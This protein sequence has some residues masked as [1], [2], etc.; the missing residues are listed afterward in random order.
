MERVLKIFAFAAVVLITACDNDWEDHYNSRPETVNES[1]WDAIQREE[2]LSLFVQYMKD[3]KYDTLFLK[4]DTYTLFIP[5]NDAFTGLLD[6]AEV[7]A[8]ML[9]YHIST[10]FIQSG[11]VADKRKLQTL[12]E[13]FALFQKINNEA[14]FDGIPLDFES[15]L[16]LN[17]K[18]FVLGE[19]ALPKPNLYEY[20]KDTNPIL[21]IYI[22]NLD[23]I[24]LDKEKSRPTGFDSLGNT[25]YDT[26]AIIYNEFEEWFFP[27][28]E[29]FRFKTATIVFPKEEDYN[30]ALTEMAQSLGSI[31]V[32]Y[33]DIPAAWQNDILIPYLLE[34]GVFENMLEPAEFIPDFTE[35]DTF[36]MKNILGDSVI[37][38]YTPS[39]KTICSNGYAYNYTDFSI[40][41]TL[42][43]GSVRLEGEHLLEETGINTY[44][45]L[46]D[47]TV[48]SD[49]RF[50]P[51]RI[52]TLGASND[53]V[54]RV[55]F[56]KGYTGQ[57]SL[58]FRVKNL[59]PRKYLMVVRTTM[60]R[61][62]V[63]DIYAND[64]YVTEIDYYDYYLFGEYWWSVTG[65]IYP[66]EGNYNRWD[67]FIQNDVEYGKTTIRL[68]YTD[69]G[70]VIQNGLVIDYIDFIPYN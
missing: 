28:R 64:Q 12:S 62:G 47:V 42:Y 43:T 50:P 5:D 27:V 44:S 3:Y 16:Y 20:F 46:E 30:N 15:P 70:G 23:S 17:G 69:P 51:E 48:I 32:D 68:D 35:V 19:V 56:P 29:E 67:C 9:E 31:Y 45:F 2:N 37:I 26:V 57:F 8:A 7:T 14:L 24:I 21:Q 18:Y 4:D 36:K 11:M 52:F 33:S 1:V 22:D 39:E 40:P 38:E 10:H 58:E 34:R 63:F 13:K 61:G 25:I 60:Y 41:D 59:F 54:M 55:Q 49:Q 65:A 53:S 6:T 66:P